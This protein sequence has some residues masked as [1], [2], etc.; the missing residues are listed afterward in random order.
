V[1]LQ[2]LAP[3]IVPT[4]FRHCRFAAESRRNLLYTYIKNA[5]DVEDPE[6]LKQ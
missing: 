4:G 3:Q 6:A 5:L 2:Q 1:G